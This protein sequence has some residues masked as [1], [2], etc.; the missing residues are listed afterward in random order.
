MSVNEWGTLEEPTLPV[1]VIEEDTEPTKRAARSSPGAWDEDLGRYGADRWNLPGYGAK[2]PKCEEW[3]AE[4]VCG[5]CGHLQLGTHNCG[6]R[7][8]PNCWGIWAKEAGV[9]ATER[10]QS[11][12]ETQ[13]KNHRRQAAHAV[14]SPPDGAVM[15]ER[16]FYDGRSRA[17]DIAQEKGFR[18]FA[19]VAHPW[20]VT[21]EAKRAYRIEEPEVGLW[22]WLRR[23]LSEPELREMIYWSP[24]YHIIGITTQEMEPG[25]GSDEWLYEFIRS[26]GA[27]ENKHDT[28]SHEE[29][30][31][32]FRYLLSHTGF[33]EESTKQAITWYGDLANAVFVE[34]AS[35][36]YQIQ[37]P[38]EGVRNVIRR[39]IEAIAGPTDGAESDDEAGDRQDGDEVGD[40]PCG[41]C[42]G[43]LIDVFDVEAY[44]RHNEPPPD[45]ATRMEIARE[46]RLGRRAPPPGLKH[47]QTEE[48]AREAFEAMQPS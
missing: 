29:V 20:R 12:R 1:G 28:E 2:G 23:E 43:V 15:N 44:L 42:D 13:P 11:F 31:G 45:V 18:G 6:R 47:P 26:F 27:Y 32:A 19:V 46:W 41:D 30:Y 34:D 35:E 8:C 25:D 17:A 9:R 36:D 4:A 5:E 33:P 7:S 14:V 22:V 21:D 3:Y 39:E 40:C 16:E 48:Q 37:K 24:H 10:V 38:S